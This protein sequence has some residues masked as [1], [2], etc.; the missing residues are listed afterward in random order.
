MN[1]SGQS[2]YP[3]APN[4]NVREITQL[5]N[6]HGWFIS[7]GSSLS[8]P[9][10]D[11][12]VWYIRGLIN[13]NTR[14]VGPGSPRRFLGH[15]WIF[16]D[17]SGRG[18][19]LIRLN[20]CCTCVRGVPELGVQGDNGKRERENF[21]FPSQLEKI[22]RSKIRVRLEVR[23]LRRERAEKSISVPDI[24]H[25]SRYASIVSKGLVE[26]SPFFHESGRINLNNRK[27]VSVQFPYRASSPLFTRTYSLTLDVH[28][29]FLRVHSKRDRVS[30][31]DAS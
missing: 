10:E 26:I 23:H 14:I 24:M 21:Y 3:R 1:A 15:Y 6:L 7:K 5:D 17:F 19:G 28:A 27:T 30:E 13:W 22:C 25:T 2:R 4:T 12:Q 11:N 18:E 20:R 31:A 16:S 9:G 29:L 8:A